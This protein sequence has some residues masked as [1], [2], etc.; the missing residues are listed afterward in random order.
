[1]GMYTEFYFRANITDQPKTQPAPIVDWLD[2]N[3][4]QDKWFEQPFDDHEFFT[5]PRWS[6]IFMGG[7]AV[8]QE[9]RPAVFRRKAPPGGEPYRHQLV[10]ASSLKDYGSE[11]EAFIDW[12]TPHLDMHVGDFLGY[13]LYE[14][15]C[16]DSDEYREHPHLFFYGRES[17]R[18]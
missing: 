17:V 18:A 9:S 3:I 10:I 13:S 1:M 11:T 4:N 14:D 5:L 2:E 16:D 12:I 15:C 8:Y 6:A 7:G